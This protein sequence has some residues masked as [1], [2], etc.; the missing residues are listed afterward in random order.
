MSKAKM[1]ASANV[2]DVNLID[3]PKQLT[4]VAVEAF[5]AVNG[6]KKDAYGPVTESF[7]NIATIATI[8]CRK[9]I[10]QEDIAKILLAVKYV[11]ESY[12]HS[13]DNLVDLCGYSDL[14]QQLYD[15]NLDE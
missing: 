1:R 4:S 12:G 11:R 5:R 9:E 2:V 7:N 14:L 3:H 13:R 8:G 6:V 10:T 15:A